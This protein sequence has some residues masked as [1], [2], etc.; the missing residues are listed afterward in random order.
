MVSNSCNALFRDIK[1]IAKITPQHFY[2]TSVERH[3]SKP[4]ENAA[5]R[6]FLSIR[7]PPNRSKGLL[8]QQ[9]AYAM[10]LHEEDKVNKTNTNT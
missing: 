4:A 10:P 5:L 9:R 7:L 6:P 3:L 2:G 8:H 1:C